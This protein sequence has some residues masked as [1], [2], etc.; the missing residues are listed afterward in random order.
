M[1]DDR[2]SFEERRLGL[3]KSIT[4]ATG[5]SP[6]NPLTRAIS[7][8]AG[9][10]AR[11]GDSV[12]GLFDPV[13]S[14]DGK[15]WQDMSTGEKAAAVLRRTQAVVG[16]ALG[17]AGLLQD[18]ADVAFANL[19]N[20]IAALLPPFPA[21]TM[22]MLYVG[23][24]HAHSHPPSLIP[25]APPVPLPSLGPIMVG[26]CVRVLIGGLPAARSG[27]LGFAPTCCGFMPIFQIKTGSSNT[28]IGGSRAARMLDICNVCGPPP[29]K[30]SLSAAQKALEMLAKVVAPAL[31]IAA[32]LG[33]AATVSDPA[34]A[35]AKALAAAMAS[36]QMAAD[37]AAMAVGNM[38]GKDPCIPPVMSPPSYG[39]VTL[40]IPNVLI[41]GFPMINTLEFAKM[42]LN[43]LKRLAAKMK[44][45][46]ARLVGKSG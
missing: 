2:V 25:P 26:N 18:M 33:E 4:D 13:K 14:P 23:L 16:T 45:L 28:F 20:P 8:A 35:S 30:R 11:Y 37:A 24:P 1:A 43:A 6:S 10:G 46:A 17:L 41:G 39:A 44:E 42:A 31:G 5:T 12:V 22:T 9:V 3:E 29:E 19:T 36:A 38:M 40:G 21:A 34:Q 15:S 32:D 27:D 7:E